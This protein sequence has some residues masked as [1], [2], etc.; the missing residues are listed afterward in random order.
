MALRLNDKYVKDFVSEAELASIQSEISAAH[1]TLLTGSGE[2]SDFLGWVDLPNNY[3]KE[4]FARIKV[5]AEKVKKSCDVFIV[6]GADLDLVAYRLDVTLEFAVA[7]LCANVACAEL[8][9]KLF[10]PYCLN[11][12]CNCHNKIFLSFLAFGLF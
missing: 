9:K 4:E 11:K 2:G 10:A 12:V 8:G 3:D 7:V 1:K 6:I 5:A